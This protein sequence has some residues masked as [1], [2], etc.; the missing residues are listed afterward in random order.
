MREE[1]VDLKITVRLGLGVVSLRDLLTVH[2]WKTPIKSP[3]E[4]YFLVHVLFRQKKK[5]QNLGP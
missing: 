4:V 2:C 3:S 1:V 5:T